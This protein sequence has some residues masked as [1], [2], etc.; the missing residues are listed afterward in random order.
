[1]ITGTDD[2]CIAGS[3]A[4][5]EVGLHHDA[6]LLQLFDKPFHK[7]VFPTDEQRREHGIVVVPAPALTQTVG[8]RHGLVGNYRSS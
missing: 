3:I 6:S 1:M 4:L 8:A 2:T 7:T 5:D